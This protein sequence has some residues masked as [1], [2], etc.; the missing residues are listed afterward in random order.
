MTS[1]SPLQAWRKAMLQWRQTGDV[2]P[3]AE[4]AAQMEPHW[5]QSILDILPSGLRNNVAGLLRR[6]LARFT[7]A[8]R[9][10][11][12]AIPVSAPGR[13]RHS[14]T[15]AKAMAVWAGLAYSAESPTRSKAGPS[16]RRPS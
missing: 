13:E 1:G 2:S 16:P 10:A 12:Q 7:D 3:L 6:R 15:D 8:G 11:A 5:R 9:L 14:V 4:A